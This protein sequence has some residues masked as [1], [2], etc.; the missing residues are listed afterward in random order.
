MEG[1]FFGVQFIK[2]TC[3]KQSA[4]DIAT[5]V[6]S[7]SVSRCHTRPGSASKHLGPGKSTDF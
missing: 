1:D 7:A 4:I 6:N 5:E 3:Q 2:T